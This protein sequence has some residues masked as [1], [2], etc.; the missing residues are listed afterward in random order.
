MNHD[1][2]L[3]IDVSRA[4]TAQAL[5]LSVTGDIDAATIPTVDARLRAAALTSPPPPLVVLSLTA[6]ESISAAGVR[7]LKHLADACA[8]RD[9]TVHIVVA[10]NTIVRRIIGITELDRGMPT[11]DDL[12]QA[13]RA[14]R[15]G[16]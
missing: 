14:G 12:G 13:L 10:P 7:M 6:V 5:I 4:A 2:S 11:F 8:E 3:P 1:G 16:N 9:I 15:P